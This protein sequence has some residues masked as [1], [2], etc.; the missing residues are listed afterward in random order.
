VK[1][2]T[3][4]KKIE[5]EGEMEPDESKIENKLRSLL[6]KNKKGTGKRNKSVE[7]RKKTNFN[8]D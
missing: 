7:K 2:R 4:E 3:K 5:D 1:K 8:L 6:F